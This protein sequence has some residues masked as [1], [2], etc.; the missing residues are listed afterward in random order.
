MT[1]K[2][3]PEKR[4]ENMGKI[5]SKDTSP[6]MVVRKLVH[7]L[8]YRYRLHRKDLPG[9]PDLVFSNLKKIIFVHGCFWHQH[10]DPLC[11]IVRVP[12]SKND[13]WIPKF[14]RNVERD[15]QHQELLAAEGWEILI[16]WEC[17]VG[18]IDELIKTINRFLSKSAN[19]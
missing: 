4:S 13:Y 12:K 1:D 18:R 8:G 5:R 6:E 14:Q 16:I 9:K 17:E 10:A 15:G 11:K 7:S 3:S 2:V 19:T